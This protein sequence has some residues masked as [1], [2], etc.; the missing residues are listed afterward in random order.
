MTHMNNDGSDHSAE[1]S[2]VRKAAHTSV[3]NMSSVKASATWA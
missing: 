2:S 3:G 1:D